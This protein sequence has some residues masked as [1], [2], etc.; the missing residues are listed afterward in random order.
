M[1]KEYA[2]S[3]QQVKEN[4]AD[5][6]ERGEVSN[7]NEWEDLKREI[8]TQEEIAAMDFKVKK[9]LKSIAAHRQK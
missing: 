8:F 1:D 9:I 3:L 2:K 5:L 6:K 7:V 4:L